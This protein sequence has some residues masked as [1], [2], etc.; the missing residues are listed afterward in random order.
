MKKAVPIIFLA[1]VLV[2]AAGIRHK[3][4][5][6]E[7]EW[8]VKHEQQKQSVEIPIGISCTAEGEYLSK[9]KDAAVADIYIDRVLLTNESIA[10]YQRFEQPKYQ[11]PLNVKDI[12]INMKGG[13]SIN[14]WKDC[15]DKTLS[16]NSEDKL[17]ITYILFSEP[18]DTEDVK[19][20]EIIGQT[21]KLD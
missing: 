6:S 19:S 15:K 14:A 10:I 21:F 5:G 1:A 12:K 3:I 17:G 20:I 9:K 16:Y 8:S 13:K 2:F 4:N 11:D 18:I 7:R